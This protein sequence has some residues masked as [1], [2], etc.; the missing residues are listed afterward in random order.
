M[1]NQIKGIGIDIVEISRVKYAVK[2][3]GDKFLNKIFTET[4]KK[5]CKRRKKMSFP[6]LAARFAAK[7]AY[8]KAL[9][10]GMRGIKWKQ[11][12]TINDQKGKPLL[13]V[14]NKK[15]PKSQL[16]LSHSKEYAI[17]MV[18]LEG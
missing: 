15:C 8:S 4:E 5:Y 11:I 3:F 7:E 16:S 17:A 12:E 1:S 18:I 2:N 14:R 10:T 9:G 13:M 6:E